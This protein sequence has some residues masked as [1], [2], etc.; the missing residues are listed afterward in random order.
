LPA[1]GVRHGDET[2]LDVELL[3]TACACHHMR[4]RAVATKDPTGCATCQVGVTIG[5]SER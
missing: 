4:L 3:V 1:H 5:E 2:I